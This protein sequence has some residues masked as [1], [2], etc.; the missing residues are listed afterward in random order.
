M[1][2]KFEKILSLFLILIYSST[3]NVFGY[4]NKS[5]INF[6]KPKLNLFKEIFNQD[7]N[8]MST[9]EYEWYVVNR[10]D[11][12]PMEIKNEVSP[13]IPKYNCSYIGDTSKKYIY[14][15]FDEGYENGYT[16]P[17]LDALKKHN[18]KAAFFVTKHYVKTNPEL[19]KRMVDEGHLV[20]NH[21]ASHPSM[22]KIKNQE[23]FN[24]EITD[25]EKSYE[26]IIGK[27]MPKYFRPPMGKYS[28]LSLHYT[29]EI[30]YKTVFWSFAYYDWEPNRQ[31]SEQEAFNKILKKS[32]NGAIFLLHA[33]SKTNAKIMDRLITEWEKQG[34]E[35]KSL[36]ELEKTN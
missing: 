21:T 17:I 24:K 30:G 15:T 7:V 18:A 22:A 1:K 6:N 2:K 12:S 31:P 14:L 23:K 28:E 27:P 19:I 35:I 34:Y 11:S 9:K 13:W 8:G 16:P 20:C 3:L 32:H 26:E 5:V 36:D 29:K 25:L 33:V 10:G 4:T